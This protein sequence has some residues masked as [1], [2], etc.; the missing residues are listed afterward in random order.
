[1]LYSTKFTILQAHSVEMWFVAGKLKLSMKNIDTVFS[2][3]Y[4]KRGVPKN[5]HTPFL[6]NINTDDCTLKRLRLI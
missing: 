6:I 3:I 4:K 5:K 2:Q 1:M